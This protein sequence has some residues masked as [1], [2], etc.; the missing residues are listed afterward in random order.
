MHKLSLVARLSLLPLTITQAQDT[1]PAIPAGTTVVVRTV[2]AIDSKTAE[3]GKTFRATLDAPLILNGQEA[4]RKGADATLR[5]IEASSAGKLKGNAELTVALVS[6]NAGA[7]VLPVSNSTVSM[8]SAGKGKK[9]LF[10]IGGG[11]AAGA[12]IGGIAGGGKGAAIG[13]AAG[14]GAGAAAAMLTGP[15]VKIPSET[16]LTFKVQ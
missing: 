2:D 14:A 11:G 9:S 15:Q 6:V 7:K 12:A 8:E 13:A 16:V 3:V 4:A 1:A 5:I 10:K